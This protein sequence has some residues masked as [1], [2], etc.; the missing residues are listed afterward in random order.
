MSAGL[1]VIIEDA[2][3]IR[4]PVAAALSGRG[5]RV[6]DRPDGSD[7][8]TVLAEHAPDL[9]ILDLM[10]PG[11]GG[12]EL[13]DVVRAR[14]TAGVL[15]LTARGSVA[16][17]VDGL[18]RGADDY[19]VKP[20]AMDE[21]IARVLAV[22]RRSGSAGPVVTVGDLEITAEGDRV[23]RRGTPV[24]LTDTE[25]RLLLYLARHHGRTVTK[26]QLLTGV[27]GYDGFDP[28]VVEVHISSLRRKLGAP[29][30]ELIR[31]VRGK[32]YRLEATG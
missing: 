14:S 22:L 32:G 25:R 28:N 16:D 2:P 29:G 12:L 1:V 27:W 8:E 11:R 9:V 10:L 15:L 4:L 7:L 24:E 21:L 3:A 6:L 17:R 26:T 23:H 20:F 31:T 5:L 13:L 18:A 19:L 30:D